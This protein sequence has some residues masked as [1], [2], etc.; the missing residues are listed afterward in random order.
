M[1]GL[2]RAQHAALITTLC[3]SATLAFAQGA[4]EP[5]PREANGFYVRM[6]AGFG[7]N[8]LSID[9]GSETTQARVPGLALDFSLGALLSRHFAVGGMMFLDT[10][11]LDLDDADPFFESGDGA[12]VSTFGATAAVFPFTGLGL[13]V[14]TAFGYTLLNVS[15]DES[16]R[17]SVAADGVGGAVW[18]GYDARFLREWSLGSVVRASAGRT[19]DGD[20]FVVSSRAI[21]VLLTA[22][23]R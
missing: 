8:H 5:A 4:P 7:V 3:S 16:A 18:L 17:Q 13:H 22:V 19:S 11:S 12:S 2:R 6:S 9:R 14:G 23:Y 15:L 21:A 10:G 1:C 20:D